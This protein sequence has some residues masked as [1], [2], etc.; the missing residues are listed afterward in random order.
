MKYIIPL[1]LLS[2]SGCA[3]HVINTTIFLKEDS[4]RIANFKG[5]DC[6]ISGYQIDRDRSATE[7]K[8]NAHIMTTFYTNCEVRTIRRLEQY[9]LK[10][11]GISEKGKQKMGSQ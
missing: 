3:A 5:E 1:L 7:K 8:L 11:W 6:A 2:L 9:E 10:Q 4:A